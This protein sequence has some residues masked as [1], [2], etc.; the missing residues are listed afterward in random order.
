MNARIWAFGVLFVAAL[1][2]G[3][4]GGDNGSGNAGTPDGGGGI[5]TC[6]PGKTDLCACAGGQTGVQTCRPDGTFAP[7]EC[8]GGSNASL[9]DVSELSDAS[10]PS[11]DCERLD[12]LGTGG[13]LGLEVEG[14]VGDASVP[15]E[16]LEC[17]Q[18]TC[19]MGACTQMPCVPGAS[20][21]V[22]GTVY[23]PTGKVP[24]HD[25]V[26]Y[27]P[28][29]EAFTPGVSC[30]RCGF[31]VDNPIAFALTDANGKFVLKDVPVGA[32]IPVVI[33][34]GKWRRQFNIS[35]VP[36]CVETA[37]GNSVQDLQCS[38]LR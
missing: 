28:N 12:G 33:Q 6:V 9:S 15:C 37:L 17:Q 4:G 29:R 3:G 26:V 23:D 35:D 32:D 5:A 27:V 18:T 10:V 19:T 8:A 38:G 2:C 24:L 1:G 30:D 25:V 21:T 31:A 22:S 7:C 11:G 20:T 36:R 13:E 34:I 16:G 14:G